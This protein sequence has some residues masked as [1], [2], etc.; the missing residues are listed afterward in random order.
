[1]HPAMTQVLAAEHVRDMMA[2]AAKAG[3]VSEARRARA[4][5]RARRRVRA[6]GGRPAAQPAL[7]PQCP[8]SIMEH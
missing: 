7:R 3:R 8:E 5:N 1:M 6:D 2:R 4:A